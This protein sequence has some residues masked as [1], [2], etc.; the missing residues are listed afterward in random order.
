MPCERLESFSNIREPGPVE[1]NFILKNDEMEEYP[2]AK[3]PDGFDT[4][5]SQQ[6]DRQRIADLILNIV[7]RPSWPLRKDDLLILANV[8]DGIDRNR[9]PR[10]EIEFPVKRRDHDPPRSNEDKE[11]SND[12]LVFKAKTNSGVHSCTRV[13]YGELMR[14]GSTHPS[15]V[16]IHHATFALNLEVCINFERAA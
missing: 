16:W 8:R 12:Q 11:E 13:S 10:E 7:R 14:M 9:V 15:T 1:V 2:N 3:A 6:G 5:Y 4:G